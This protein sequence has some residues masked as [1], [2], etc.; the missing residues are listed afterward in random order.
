MLTQQIPRNQIPSFLL[1][2]WERDNAL[3]FDL[4]WSC[5][6]CYRNQRSPRPNYTDLDLSGR[7]LQRA[8]LY[9]AILHKVNFSKINLWGAD[10]RGA[11]L[12]GTNL[13]GAD[14]NMAYRPSDPPPGWKIVNNR[15]QKE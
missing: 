4:S 15:L 3:A 6:L 9:K 11:N 14:L 8:F 1:P 10:L 13:Q 7:D 2:L 5:Y 12:S